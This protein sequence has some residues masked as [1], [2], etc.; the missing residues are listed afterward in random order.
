M[1]QLLAYADRAPWSKQFHESLPIAGREE[2]L[3]LRM[4]HT[5]AQGNLHAKTGTTNDVVALSGYVAARDGEVLAFAFLYNGKDRWNARATID[6]MGV[7]LRD[8]QR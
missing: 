4:R 1:V 3:R 6:A 5:P 8:F 2:T 7:T